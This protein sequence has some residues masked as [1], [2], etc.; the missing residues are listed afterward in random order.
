MTG[1]ELRE[2][3]ETALPESVLEEVAEAARFHQRDRKRDSVKFLRTMLIAAASP[4][5][6]RQADIMRHYFEMGT[7]R[8]VRGSFYDW[9]GPPLEKAMI[10]LSEI[11]LERA[12]TQVVDLPGILAGVRD[13]RIVDSETVALDKRLLAEYPGTGDHAALKVHKTLSV[14]TGT[15]VAYHVSPA[16]EHDSPHLKLDESWRGMGLLVDLGYASVERLREC[17]TFGINIVIRLKDNWKPKVQRVARADL[18]KTFVPGTDLDIFLEEVYLNLGNVI[19]VDVTVGAAELPMRLVGVRV[20]DKGYRFYLTNVGRSLGPHQIAD[21]YRVRWEIETNN[22]LD[23]SSHR[24]EQIDAKR[25]AAVRA[26]IHAS[27]IS[28]ILV[29]SIVHAHNR[30]TPTKVAQR[31]RPPLHAGLV[32]RMLATAALRIADACELEGEAAL[33]EWTKIADI[34]VHTG[35]DPNWR[36]RPSIL[37]QLRGWSAAPATKKKLSSRARA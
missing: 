4:A 35:E 25:G 29:N 32:A 24:L 10:K 22:K 3:I 20:P 31:T 12:R 30:V 9:F 33:V 18:K 14:G 7:E 26:M 21:L 8:V 2:I 1:A 23:K 36:A 17:Q 5:G 11:V 34:I 6:G 37:D 28:S 15:V 13:W 16:R 19:D 27:L